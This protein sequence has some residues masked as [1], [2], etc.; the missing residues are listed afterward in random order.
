MQAIA[1]HSQ[2]QPQQ[3]AAV[4]SS[5]TVMGVSLAPDERVV[6]FHTPSSTLDKV[7]LWVMFVLT[8]WFLVGFIFLWMVL[9]HDKKNPKAVAVTTH[10]VLVFPGQGEPVSYW[11]RDIV[12]VEP[13]RQNAHS[14]GG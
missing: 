6:Y 9:T 5:R 3:Y 10:R 7:T 14:G 1:Q 8:F 12:D 4:A 2:F 11:L 13:V